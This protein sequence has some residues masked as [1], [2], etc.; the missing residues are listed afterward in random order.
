MQQGQ[1][2][3]DCA[4]SAMQRLHERTEVVWLVKEGKQFTALVR[5]DVDPEAQQ[6]ELELEL[7]LAKA[8]PAKTKDNVALKE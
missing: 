1:S 5:S 4:T 2:I 3:A 8:T 7:E 6:Y